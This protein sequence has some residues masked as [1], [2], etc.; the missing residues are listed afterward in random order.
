MVCIAVYVAIYIYREMAVTGVTWVTLHRWNKIFSGYI[1]Q[2][3]IFPSRSF[4]V[5]APEKNR[6][7]LAGN[8]VQFFFKKLAGGVKPL[9]ARENF[10]L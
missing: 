2:Q 10:T 1:A 5:L 4:F 6:L 9:L 3:K 7:F 8:D